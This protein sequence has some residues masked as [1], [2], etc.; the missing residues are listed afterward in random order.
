MGSKIDLTG[1]RFNYLTVLRDSGRRSK[2]GVYWVCKC[3]CGRETVCI[4]GSLR[5]GS[6]KS[7]GCSI[8]YSRKGNSQ[9]RLFVT[10]RNMHDRCS[11]PKSNRYHIYGAIGVSVCVEWAD[12]FVFEKWALANGY[13]DELTIDRFPNK[14]GNYEPGN[15]RWATYKEQARNRKKSILVDF[16]GE[17]RALSEW[18]ELYDVKYSVLAKRHKLGWDFFRALTEPKHLEQVRSGREYTTMIAQYDG[19]V[20]ATI[21]TPETV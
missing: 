16:G 19:S 14:D 9:K 1:Q 8:S 15:C 3:D 7:C 6:I 4:A 17:T 2:S 12:Y 11:N 5:N 10:W 21:I 13:T 18:A 20:N